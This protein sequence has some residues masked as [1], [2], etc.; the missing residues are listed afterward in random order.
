[1]RVT[2]MCNF[3][4]LRNRFGRISRK[5]GVNTETV[6]TGIKFKCYTLMCITN[7]KFPQIL[8]NSLGMKH[9]KCKCISLMYAHTY[10]HVCT[11]IHTCMHTHTHMYTQTVVNFL[12]L[13]YCNITLF[14]Y[15][16]ISACAQ[17]Y[18]TLTQI[19][20]NFLFKT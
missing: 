10:T 4:M 2:N 15:Q 11:H 18:S 12:L 17:H 16:M 7:S 8:I 20:H 6:W 5:S 13:T 14:I 19:K 1:M 3:S 9:D